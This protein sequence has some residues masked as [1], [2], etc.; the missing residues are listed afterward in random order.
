MVC[1]ISAGLTN[2]ILLTEQ[3]VLWELS[4]D[5]PS[6]NERPLYFFIFE[7]PMKDHFSCRSKSKQTRQRRSNVHKFKM[8]W[9]SELGLNVEAI[10][11]WFETKYC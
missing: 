11:L 3:S 2:P 10:L 8:Y 6:S 7:P 1:Y 9:W 5:I 4:D